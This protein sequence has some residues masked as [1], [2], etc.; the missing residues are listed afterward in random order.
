MAEGDLSGLRGTRKVYLR[1]ISNTEKEILDLTRDFDPH[2]EDSVTAFKHSFHEKFNEIKELDDK[3]LNL[4]KPE[5]KE[6]ELEEIIYRDDKI[7]F[8]IA[9]LDRNLNKIHSTVS[10]RAPS[11]STIEP[12]ASDIKVRLPKLEI[13][14]FNGN[15][16]EWQSFWDQFSSGIHN[17]ENIS[18]IG[19]FT[20]L[21]L[22]LCDSANYTIMLTSENYCQAIE[23]LIRRYAN[24]Q[25]LI[26]A[27]MKKLV[28][29]PR[30][31]KP[32]DV[33]NLRKLLDEVESSL[34]NLKSLK[35]ETD[36]YGQLLGPLLSE[37]LPNDLRLRIAREFEN[38]VWLLDRLGILKKEVE[39]KEQS[40]L[41]GTSF[42]EKPSDKNKL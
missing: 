19:K 42:D 16:L 17:K 39:S 35:V 3:I 12:S 38:D 2:N 36:S 14:N 20:Y 23:L 13:K 6:N 21:K 32:Y 18:N 1:T 29:I 34:R 8:T 25:T 31:K 7:M 10:L 33:L 27:H 5:E 30:V 24:P 28:S 26:A 37:K 15:I 11:V 40:I 22:F 4:L 41:V 9:K